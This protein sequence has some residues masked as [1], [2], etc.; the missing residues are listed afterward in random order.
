MEL[1]AEL[2]EADT[3]AEFVEYDEAE[4]GAGSAGKRPAAVSLDSLKDLLENPNIR[5]S[6]RKGQEGQG[7]STRSANSAGK[8]GGDAAAARGSMDS[9]EG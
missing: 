2:D 9:V 7:Q 1:V 3:K 8:G 5:S 4:E 6:T